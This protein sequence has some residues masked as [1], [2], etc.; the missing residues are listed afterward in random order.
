MEKNDETSTKWKYI[1][2][3]VAA[4]WA[5]SQERG[6]QGVSLRGARPCRYLALP[7]TLEIPGPVLLKQIAPY[8]QVSM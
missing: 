6:T 4:M 3:L 8:L 1:P 5:D 2:P 7:F